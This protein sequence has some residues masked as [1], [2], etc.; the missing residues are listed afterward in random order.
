MNRLKYNNDN[1]HERDNHIYF[2]EGPHIY[3]HDTLGKL[4]SLTETISSYLTRLTKS[5]SPHSLRRNVD[6]HL[7]NLSLNGKT[8][9]DSA[10][11][12]MRI[13]NSICFLSL[14]K[15]TMFFGSSRTS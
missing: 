10:H 7:K 5:G 15:K 9:P 11:N 3:T 8:K 4:D 2:D 12:S 6:V 1:W 14:M 13:S